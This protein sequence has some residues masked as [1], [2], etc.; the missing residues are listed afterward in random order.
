VNHLLSLLSSTST[1]AGLISWYTSYFLTMGARVND[2]MCPAAQAGSK[3]IYLKQIDLSFL[4]SP[5]KN[6]AYLYYLYKV[7]NCLINLLIMFTKIVNNK[8][9]NLIN[10]ITKVENVGLWRI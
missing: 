9:Y 7:C 5:Q 2:F 4:G 6:R 8:I 1:I 3:V 10:N